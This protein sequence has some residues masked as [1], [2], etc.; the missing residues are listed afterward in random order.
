VDTQIRGNGNTAISTAVT[1]IVAFEDP[2]PGPQIVD[3]NIIEPDAL[4]VLAADNKKFIPRNGG[5]V[6][7]TGFRRGN[8]GIFI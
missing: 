7:I 6:G 1:G 5:E 4:Q 8:E 3:V 2:I